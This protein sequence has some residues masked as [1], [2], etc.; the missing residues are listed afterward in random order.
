MEGLYSRQY[1]FLSYSRR[2]LLPEIPTLMTIY[3]GGVRL[4]SHSVMSVD[5]VRVSLPGDRVVSNGQGISSRFGAAII[6]G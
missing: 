1:I 5:A 2:E 3:K 6:S 4:F